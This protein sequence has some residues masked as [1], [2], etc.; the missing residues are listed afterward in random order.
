MWSHRRSRR[1][2]DP[3]ATLRNYR[4][5]PREEFVQSLADQVRRGAP[6]PPHGLV[7]P[8]LCRRGLDHDPRDVRL[9]RRARICRLRG[10]LDVLGREEGRRRP[11]AERRRAQVFGLGPVPRRTRPLA[12][13]PANNVAGETTGSAAG[14]V[15]GAQTLPFTG[16]SLLVTV[17]IGLA[18]LTTGLILRRRERSDS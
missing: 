6:C 3:G 18:L 13:P 2:S 9:V 14:A 10:E 15:A 4:A 12:E 8:R 1:P 17:L 16:V 5:E 11:Q 7:T